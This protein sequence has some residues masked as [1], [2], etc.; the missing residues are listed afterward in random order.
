MADNRKNNKIF[1]EE[2]FD[3]PPKQG[4]WFSEHIKQI[5]LAA[6]VIVCV[7][8]A[9]FFVPRGCSND[10]KQVVDTLVTD[11]V[12][13]DSVPHVV[14]DSVDSNSVETAHK[15]VEDETVNNPITT[16]E[17]KNTEGDNPVKTE[18]VDMSEDVVKEALSVIRG[19]YGNNPDRRRMLKE[20]YQEIQNKV[21][22]MYRNG[23][24]K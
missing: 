4:N 1:S 6:F 5:L 17:E 3:K 9:I 18:V 24:V 19:N 20:R 7:V 2:D 14:A 11:S 12:S 22:E 10:E 15:V 13:N 16:T 8:L 21:N 23:Q